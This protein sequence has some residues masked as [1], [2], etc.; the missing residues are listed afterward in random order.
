MI[1]TVN[2][3]R[4]K[5]GFVERYEKQIAIGLFVFSIAVIFLAYFQIFYNLSETVLLSRAERAVRNSQGAAYEPSLTGDDDMALKAKDTDKDGLT[6]FDELKIYSTSPYLEDSDSDGVS[7]FEEVQNGQDPNCPMGKSCRPNVGSE[8]SATLPGSV[9]SAIPDGA[10]SLVSGQAQP[11]EV[12][13]FL[14]DSG[15]DR[16]Q[17]DALSDEEVIRLYKQTLKDFNQF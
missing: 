15:L 11:D 3:S 9:G 13:Q 8:S 10:D 6:D 12:R 1:T 5:N 17:V 16:S 7:D 4:D 14:I 2:Q